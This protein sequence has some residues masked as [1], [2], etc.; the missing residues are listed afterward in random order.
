MSTPSPDGILP[1]SPSL[2]GRILPGWIADRV[3]RFNVMIFTS[4]FSGIIVLALWCHAHT[5]ASVIVFA[6]LFGFS[7]GAFVSISPALVAQISDVRQIGVRNGSLFAVIS[8]AALTGSPIAG[9]I[10]THQ[11]GRFDGLQIFAGS[12]M[13]VGALFFTAARISLAGFKVGVKV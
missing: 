8:V 11:H 10:S 3:G 12:F 6:A 9:A 7:S 13:L 2:F 1:D 4:F 5:N